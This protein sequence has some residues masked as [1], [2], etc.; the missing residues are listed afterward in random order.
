VT[1]GVIGILERLLETKASVWDCQNYIIL[2]G[3]KKYKMTM[4]LNG[5]FDEC[6]G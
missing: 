6:N 3:G 4:R 1:A 2:L 5:W